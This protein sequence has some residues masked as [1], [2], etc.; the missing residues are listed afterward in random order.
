MI[1]DELV[2]IIATQ[3]DIQKTKA[4]TILATVI[5]TIQQAVASGD[6]VTIA[7]F[8][9]FEAVVTKPRVGRNPA[10][11]AKVD[12]IAKRRPK[13]V[14]GRSFRDVVCGDGLRVEP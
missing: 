13:F 14:A 6:K 11:G 5:A 4:K 10:T 8:G 1:K 2:D 9:T 12:I 7:G 3:H